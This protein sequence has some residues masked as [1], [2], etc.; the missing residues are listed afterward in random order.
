MLETLKAIDHRLFL[1]GNRDI[2]N[3]FFDWVMPILTDSTNILIT[4]LVVYAIFI[5]RSGDKRRAGRY[6]IFAIITFAVTDL[7]AYRILKPYFG[8]LR[9]SHI[10]NFTD[11]IHN[12]LQG[13][14]FLLGQKSSLS[15][16][17]NHAANAFG[18]ALFWT[19]VFPKKWK[20]FIPIAALIAFTRV[21]CGVHYPADITFGAIFGSFVGYLVYITM[22]EFFFATDLRLKQKVGFSFFFVL[23]AVYVW[24]LSDPFNTEFKKVEK[25][26]E[27]T[28]KEIESYVVKDTLKVVNYNTKFAGGRISF[29]FNCI[30]DRVLMDSNEV[31][32]N[33][34]R[35]CEVIKG[36]EPD[37]L[38]L[39]EVDINSHRCAAINMLQFILDNTE[40]N[41][42]IYG[43]HW[44][45]DFIPKKGLKHINSGNAI[46]SKWK[47]EEGTRYAL[48]KLSNQGF[49]E[50]YFYIKRNF[51]T[52]VVELNE[53]KLTLITSHLA[54]YDQDGTRKRQ[55]NLLRAHID[56][57]YALN[58]TF[59]FAGDLNLISPYATKLKGFDDCLCEGEYD[60]DDYS[61]TEKLL[62]PLYDSYTFAISP[63]RLRREEAS[64]HTHSVHPEIFWN[65][66]ID[67]IF[68]PKGL[69]VENSGK[70]H[71]V[72]VDTVSTME[73]SDHAP[74][75]ARI[76]L[77]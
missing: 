4:T 6:V 9:P 60:A 69:I 72:A 26:Q 34:D 23:I 46:L 14:K 29:F 19:M 36:L 35:L 11:G 49:L 28:A 59:L 51:L 71:Q 65:R 42:G 18:Q 50:Q 27:F 10:N 67:Y 47:I 24:A 7:I 25:A 21:Y 77:H 53:K 48:P 37:I 20:I 74:I 54:A 40:M 56:S 45:S 64:H 76:V 61:G 58:E 39:Q 17:S 12:F 31:Y 38:I 1:L 22:K 5:F 2:S 13:A 63:E 55:L 68:S 33:L 73:V 3:P 57:L 16:P 75:S 70:T 41:Y 52:G 66:K 15:F 43:S 32:E 8:R 44:K 62:Q 30:G